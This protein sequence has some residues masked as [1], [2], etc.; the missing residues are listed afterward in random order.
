MFTYLG[1]SAGERYNKSNNCYG[2]L[3]TRW[4]WQTCL[5]TDTD[6]SSA[7]YRCHFCCHGLLKSPSGNTGNMQFSS[8][9]Y[10][11]ARK[12]P[13]ALHPVS[14][15][16]PQRCLGNGSPVRLIDDGR[17]SSFWRRSSSASSFHASLLQRSMLWCNLIYR[18]FGNR[19][20]HYAGLRFVSTGTLVPSLLWHFLHQFFSVSFCSQWN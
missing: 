2:T 10:L 5:H 17:L 7:F 6:R 14:Q 15:K 19:R 20:L 3:R 11:C 12:S 8:R 13:C 9:W 1:C 4:L 16:F 18:R